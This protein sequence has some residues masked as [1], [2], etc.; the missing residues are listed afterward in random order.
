MGKRLLQFCVVLL[1]LSSPAVRAD[2]RNIADYTLRIHIFN[3]SE[4]NFYHNRYEDEA[5][6]EG[7]ANL[8]E[9]GEVHGVDFSFECDQKVKPSFGHETYPARW[10]KPG[11]QLTVLLPVFGKSNSYF[12]CTFKTDVKPYTYTRSPNGM[13][14]SESPEKYKAW[15]QAHDYDPEHGKNEPTRGGSPEPVAPAGSPGG[16]SME[17]TPAK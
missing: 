8:F 16:S 10:K 3:R 5:K 17:P 2:S 15:M 6:G 7:R 9:N 4:T 14:G 11:Q 1:L 13:M 12:T